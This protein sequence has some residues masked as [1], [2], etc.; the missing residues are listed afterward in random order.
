MTTL[1]PNTKKARLLF[2]SYLW[3]RR[4]P[5]SLY[6]V[7]NNCSKAKRDAWKHCVEL[8]EK[9]GGYALCIVGHNTMAF[10]A[11]FETENGV[12]YITKQNTYLIPKKA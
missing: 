5:R 3:M 4:N 11:G 7:Y 9:L 8:C 1:N 12:V 6:D 10:S 2:H